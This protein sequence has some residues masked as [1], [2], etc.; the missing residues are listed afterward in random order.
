M[1]QKKMLMSAVAEVF[2][3]QIM[4]FVRC[5]INWFHLH[6]RATLLRLRLSMSHAFAHQVAI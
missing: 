2:A 1:Q 5:V 6:E 4:S 3:R